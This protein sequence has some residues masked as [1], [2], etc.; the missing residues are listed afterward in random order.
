GPAVD[1]QGVVLLHPMW[2]ISF[3]GM[4]NWIQG[5]VLEQQ[6]W[7]HCWGREKKRRKKR[8]SSSSAFFFRSSNSPAPGVGHLLDV[9]LHATNSFSLDRTERTKG[10]RQ[11]GKN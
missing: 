10:L 8:L 2:A 6:R 11:N 1:A 7:P 4:F 3:F 5:I 9:Q